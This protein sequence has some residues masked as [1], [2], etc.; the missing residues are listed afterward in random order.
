MGAVDQAAVEAGLPGAALM[1]SAGRET[2]REIRRAWPRPGRAVVLV[3]GGKNGGDGLVVARHLR[4]AGWAVEL[5]LLADPARLTGD[6]ALQWRLVE[7]MGLRILRVSK[8][9][10]PL[11]VEGATVVVDALL[12]TGLKGDVREPVRSAI[13]ALVGGAPPVVAVD[14]PS[15]LDGRTG[16]VHGI[17][18][19]ALVTVTF[20]FPKPGLFLADGPAHVGRLV[21]AT[22][23][24]PSGALAAAGP[25]PLAWITI[26]TA[27]RALPPRRHDAHKGSAGRLFVVAGSEQYRGAAA[28]VVGAALR[29]G[30][31][32]CAIATPEPVVGFLLARH[33]EAIVA[34]LP[35][36][37]S[38]ALA[39]RAVDLVARAAGEADA[40]AIGP[41]L[42]IGGGV[43]E[44]VEAALAA[45]V[46][47]VLDADALNVLAG[48]PAPVKREA[49]TILTPHPGELGR[50]SGRPAEQVDADRVEA[51]RD[52]ARAHRSTVL[53]KGSPTVVAGADG[54]TRL[55][56]T[57]NPGL[58]TGG[59][60]DV[61]TGVL[62]SLLAQGVDPERAAR[63]AP[64][65]HGL[66]AD[67]AARDLGERGLVPGDLLRYVP[68]VVREIAAGRGVD[69]LERIDHR[70]G[71]LLAAT[72]GGA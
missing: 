2:A 62:G 25:S 23:A 28:L 34:S 21:A 54:D 10:D 52:A 67:W 13:E 49:P 31:G 22:L 26:G 35:V 48:D 63:A 71:D 29:S 44:L 38:G 20:G 11:E 64:F 18:P 17:A 58:A 6:A 69:L 36:T 65:L 3:G 4:E 51:A 43:R 37:R 56:L 45:G 46:P 50:W 55:N 16:R 15:G 33:P 70:Y 24:Y 61:L 72:G 1:E 14:T 9:D 66:A 27:V 53:L 40:V 68:L 60:G 12:G 47:T 42:G 30:V 5:R 41:G 57:G 32:M 7:P 39:A 8:R 59:S 19:R